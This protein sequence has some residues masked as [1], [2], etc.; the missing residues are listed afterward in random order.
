MMLGMVVAG[1]LSAAEQR[2]WAAFP[3]GML[4]DFGT[5]NAEDDD[6]SGGE[7]WRPDRQVRAAVLAMLLCGAV[8]VEPG[9]AGEICLNRARVIGKLGFPGAAFKHR[10]RLNRCY[11]PDGI[12]LSEATTRIL[13]LQGCRVGEVHLDSARI[14]GA[15]NLRGAHLHGEGGPALTARG[16]TVTADM[17]CDGEFQ[18][19]GE[20][21]LSA[22]SIGGQLNFGGAHLDGKDS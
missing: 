16:L 11:L 20:I 1:D 5:G 9:E 2:V 6:P 13:D 22:A 3:T 8:D 17:L 19:A 15:L 7:G 12:D 18:A 14:N 4:V 10:L 21:D